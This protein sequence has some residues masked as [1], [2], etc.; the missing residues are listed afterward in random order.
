MITVLKHLKRLGVELP[1]EVFHYKDELHDQN[2]RR[3][4]E[5]FGATIREVGTNG[6]FRPWMCSR[7]ARS[8]EWANRTTHGR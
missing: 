8:K 6:D 3:E 4:I 1:V 5:S 2:Q 7:Y